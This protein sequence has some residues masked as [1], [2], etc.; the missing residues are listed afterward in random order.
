[1]KYSLISDMHINHPQPRTPYDLLEEVV[2][3]AGDTSNGLEGIKY[4]QKLRN[5][6][7]I[8]IA[9]DGNHEHY[10]NTAQDRTIDATT[11]RF[12]EEFPSAVEVNDIVFIQRNGWYPVDDEQAWNNYMNDKR[13]CNTDA[14]EVSAMAKEHVFEIQFSLDLCRS[15]GKKAVVTTHTAPCEATLDPKFFGYFGN[16][17]YWNP[18]MEHILKDYS[19]VILAWNHGHTHCKGHALV[20]GVNVYANPRGYPGENIHWL[21]QTIEVNV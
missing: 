13:N 2:V 20:H 5:K 7:H 17:Y 19:D 4:L 3:V 14:L 21:P 16:E 18:G 1:M 15:Q 11:R 9:V 6:G 10:S 8:V 12:R